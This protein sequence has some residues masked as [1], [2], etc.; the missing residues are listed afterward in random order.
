M[1]RA[2]AASWCAREVE[3]EETANGRT[4][5]VVTELPY[6]VNKAVLQER[7][8]ELVRDKKLDGIAGDAATRAIGSGMRL[9]IE[10][11][12]D[13]NPHTVLNHLYKH[14][15][16]QQAF[17]FNMLALVDG[18]P[19]LLPLKRL[20]VEFL[21]YR[22]EVLTRRTQFELDKARAAR[23]HPGRPGHRARQPRR[24]DSDHPRG[25]QP[26]GRAAAA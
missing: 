1:R 20:L 8:A 2:A 25:G 11:K 12:R 4:Q 14:T 13:A 24:G 21:D 22:Q 15:A 5:I 23:P 17:G 10:I 18:Q 26:R 19:Q 3:F 7:I 9:V 16:M 6:Q